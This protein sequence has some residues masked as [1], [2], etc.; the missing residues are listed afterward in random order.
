MRSESSKYIR[1]DRL[2][3]VRLAAVVVALAFGVLAAPASVAAQP[4]AKVWKV[5]LLWLGTEESVAPLFAK[6]ADGLRDLG[7]VEARN[8]FFVHRFANGQL[9]RVPELAGDLVRLGVDVI[10][11]PTNVE[12]AAAKRATTTIPIVMIN[13]PDPVGAG[14]VASLVHPGGN[15]TGQAMAASPEVIGKR[16]ALLTEIVPGLSRVGVLRQAGAGTPD[17]FVAMQ[18][19]AAKL[20][21]T[22][23]EIEIKGPDDVDDALATLKRRRAGALLVYGGPVTWMRRQQIASLALKHR[24]PGIHG[25]AE[26]ARVGLLLAYGPNLPEF[27]RS[28]PRYIDKIFKG[29]KPADLP[30]EQPTKYDLVINLKTAKVLGVTIPQSLL[31][32]ASEIIQ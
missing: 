32:Q 29:A 18:A 24:L 22:L 16:L 13:P 10:V 11:T 2:S 28:I 17:E 21:V 30:V 15:V 4:A 7:Y 31:L 20:R 19:A 1:T 23:D 12:T 25:L 14:F 8:V 6:L 9:E 3:A 27:Y 5:G 26:Y